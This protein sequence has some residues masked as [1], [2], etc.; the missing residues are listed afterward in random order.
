DAHPPELEADAAGRAEIAPELVEAG[1]NVRHGAR[2]VVSRRL[3]QHRHTVRRIT[4]VKD[5]L[6]AG[7]IL[8]RGSPDRGL[9]LVL[10]HIDRPVVLDEAA[11]GGVVLRT[12]A[13]G[14]DRDRDFLADARERLGHLV[15]AREHSRLPRF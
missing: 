7:A 6:V 11:E 9:D 1:A 5:L 3:H 4:F 12:W 15:P 10:G 14:L 13:A 8:A 2:R